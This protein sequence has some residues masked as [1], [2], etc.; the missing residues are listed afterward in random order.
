MK[1]PQGVG[2][3]SL[4][5]L[6]VEGS[7][8]GDLGRYVSKGT[9][10]GHVSIGTPGGVPGGRTPLLGTVKDMLNKALEWTSVSVGALVLR[11]MEGHSFLRVF[12]IKRYINK[13]V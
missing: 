2:C 3:I 11:N 1:G 12:E 4:K 5:R 10:Y 7:F 9:G 13:Y 8:T 6:S